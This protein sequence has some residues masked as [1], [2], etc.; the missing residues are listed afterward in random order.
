ML[1]F[2]LFHY[3]ADFLQ[4]I[5]EARFH[6]WQWEGKNLGHIGKTVVTIDS[7]SD[8]LGLFFWNIL[9]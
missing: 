8:Y 2:C 9:Q 1:M 4:S 7:E 3:L 5:K 6:R